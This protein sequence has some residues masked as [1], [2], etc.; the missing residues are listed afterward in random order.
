MRLSAPVFQLK[1]SAKSLSR[2]ENISLNLAL[3]C[4]AKKEGF[5]SWSLLAARVSASRS[6]NELE[7]LSRLTPGDLVLLGARPR[8]GKTMTG[9]KLIVT[10][11]K[12]GRQG[13][14]YTLEYTLKDVLNRL[15]EIDVNPATLADNFKLDTSDNICAPY[16]I[17]QLQSVPCGTVIVIDY[18]QLLDQK[19]QNPK[20]STQVSELKS[21][22]CKAGLIVVL[23]TQIDRTYDLSGKSHPDISDVRLPNPIDLTLFTKTCFLHNGEIQFQTVV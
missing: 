21:F 23:I 1:R 7:L 3:D 19:R 22:A 20:L 18:L 8:Q 5:Q 16:I 15:E 11:I 12:D 9:L 4:I 6:S 14:F 10:A 2:K 17:D 13:F